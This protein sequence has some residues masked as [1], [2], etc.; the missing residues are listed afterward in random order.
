MEPTEELQNAAEC[1]SRLLSPVASLLFGEE[2]AA[3]LLVEDT[4]AAG[5]APAVVE[6]A[7]ASIHMFLVRMRRPP[8]TNVEAVCEAYLERVRRMFDA[9]ITQV[10]TLLVGVSAKDPRTF[11][12]GATGVAADDREALWGAVS[13]A[14]FAA[15]ES[16]VSLHVEPVA[17]VQGVLRAAYK[18][19]TKSW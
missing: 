10:G 4:V 3:N 16:A 5:K 14:L 19:R 2:K 6:M 1:V 9:P 7:P 18:I 15:E 8:A 12:L 11:H 13:G 17:A